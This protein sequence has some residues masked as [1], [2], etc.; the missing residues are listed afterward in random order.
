M[1]YLTTKIYY[2][3]NISTKTILPEGIDHKLQHDV[4]DLSVQG[5]LPVPALGPQHIYISPSSKVTQIQVIMELETLCPAH[6]DTKYAT[7]SNDTNVPHFTLFNEQAM[8]YF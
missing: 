1:N 2:I 8:L 7:S 3:Y 4:L 5:R 6:T